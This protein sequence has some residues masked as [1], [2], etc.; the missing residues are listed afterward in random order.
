MQTTFVLCGPA[1]SSSVELALDWGIG[2]IPI[3]S[4]FTHSPGPGMSMQRLNGRELP[5]ATRWH[6]KSGQ[7]SL[8][9]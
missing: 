6:S 9:P 2:S 1:G 4:R 5:V 3:G 8:A 7:V